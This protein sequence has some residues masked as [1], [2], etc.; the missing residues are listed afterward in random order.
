MWCHYFF[1]QYIWDYY[2]RITNAVTE[3]WNITLL[4]LFQFSI[5]VWGTAYPTYRGRLSHWG[6]VT[7]MCVSAL[8]SIGSDNGLAWDI[9]D[10]VLRNKLQWKFNRNSYFSWKKVFENVVWNIVPILSRAQCVNRISN[11]M[12]YNKSFRSTPLQA[13]YDREIFR[14]VMPI[15]A[16][17]VV[18]CSSAYWCIGL[19]PD[20]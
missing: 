3:L 17:W 5:E 7:H 20:T 19:L 15:P 2:T 18:P 4:Y 8:T 6:R 9:V 14:L 16:V 1:R 12:R 10:W 13:V 11:S